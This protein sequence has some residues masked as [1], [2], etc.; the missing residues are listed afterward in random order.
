MQ[1]APNHL[2]YPS[3]TSRH[4]NNLLAPPSN[5]AQREEKNQTRQDH[6]KH[7]CPICKTATDSTVH[8]D[9]PFCSERCRERDLGNWASEKYVVSEPIFNEDDSEEGDRKT[10]LLDLPDRGEAEH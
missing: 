9:F 7:K 10:I 6:M 1:F 4:P 3:A 2:N 5:G 8:A